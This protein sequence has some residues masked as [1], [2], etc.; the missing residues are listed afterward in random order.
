MTI[1]L[2][3]K[4]EI[5]NQGRCGRA[6]KFNLD[7]GTTFALPFARRDASHKR[8]RFSAAG[9]T[10]NCAG[11]RPLYARAGISFQ[12]GSNPALASDGQQGASPRV[13]RQSSPQPSTST[14][15]VNE[16]PSLAPQ[17]VSSPHPLIVL[18]NSAL[19]SRVLFGRLY[20]IVIG[21]SGNSAAA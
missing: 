12:S 14:R 7:Q 19:Y 9:P 5:N 6:M 4:G 18:F 11:R 17:R 2:T 21:A 13:Q 20:C 8:R 3:T 10:R 16:A 15:S 1:R